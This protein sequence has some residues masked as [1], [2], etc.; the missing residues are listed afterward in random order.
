MKDIAIYG[1]GGL[2]REVKTIIDAIN[3]K[4]KTYNFIGYFDDDRGKNGVIGDLNDLNKW[5]SPLHL[6]I[7]IGAPAIKFK[8]V[9]QITSPYVSFP[10]LIHPTVIIGNLSKVTIGQG[11]V[12]AA[13]SIL[14]TDIHIGNH[15]L[16]NLNT[17]IGHDVSIGRFTSVM[18]GVNIAGNIKIG[19]LVLVGAGASLINAIVIGKSAIVGAG[20]VVL[21][22]VKEETTVVGVPA[23][24]KW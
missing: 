3:L 12:L 5:S 10:I 6:I 16:I 20:A 4:K 17:T 11:T 22:E 1:A 24:Q 7:G 8:L 23:N 15:V 19:E 21:R 14:T 2:G 18:P 9:S 13:G